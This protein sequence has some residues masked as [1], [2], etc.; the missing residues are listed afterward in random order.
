MLSTTNFSDERSWFAAYQLQTV[1]VLLLR[2]DAAA[3]AER[4]AQLHE[5]KLLGAVDDQVFGKSAQVAADLRAP[6]QH[7]RWKINII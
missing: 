2:H 4:V 1:G 7:V 3:G 6:E 5:G